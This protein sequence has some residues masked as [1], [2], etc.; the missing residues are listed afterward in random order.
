MATITLSIPDDL[1]KEMGLSKEIN[2]SEVARDAIRIKI[3]QFR[4][5]R[6]ITSRSQLSQED[7]LELGKQINESLN[8]RYK[9]L[10]V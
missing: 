3:N 8:Q 7:A 9:D 4:I 6:A 2:W 5:L 1:M 10:G